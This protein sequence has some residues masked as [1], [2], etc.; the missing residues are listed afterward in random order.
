MHLFQAYSV[1]AYSLYQTQT[2][3]SNTRPRLLVSSSWFHHLWVFDN[4]FV[5]E[6]YERLISRSKDATFGAP[7]S[8]RVSPRPKLCSK[9]AKV[10]MKV[11]RK[12]NKGLKS[13]GV[14]EEQEATRSHM[15]RK[16]KEESSK[17]VTK[18]KKDLKE[19]GCF[20]QLTTP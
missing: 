16:R 13:K 18:K 1:Q 7:G 3:R 6:I 9:T 10:G 14:K 5:H 12:T 20:T 8:E 11:Q 2:F 17:E 4:A 19:C 15:L